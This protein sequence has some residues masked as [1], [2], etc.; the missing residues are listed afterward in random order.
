MIIPSPTFNPFFVGCVIFPD[1]PARAV[2]SPVPMPGFFFTY[3]GSEKMKCFIFMNDRIRKK[4][5]GGPVIRVLKEKDGSYVEGNVVHIN[6]P[7]VVRYDPH[8]LKA[9]KTHDVKA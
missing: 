2:T 3:N 1:L 7:S 5:P 6:G 9:C 8:G 4:D